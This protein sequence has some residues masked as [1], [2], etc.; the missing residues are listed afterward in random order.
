MFTEIVG[1]QLAMLLKWNPK[2]YLQVT[3]EN[4][5]FAELLPMT[6]YETTTWFKIWLCHVPIST[7]ARMKAVNC[8]IDKNLLVF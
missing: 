7:G 6:P 1:L 3:V 2:N 5:N 4:R 8:W